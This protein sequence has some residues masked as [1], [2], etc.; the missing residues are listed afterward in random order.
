MDL[1]AAYDPYVVFSLAVG[2]LLALCVAAMV[3]L[4][5]TH[6]VSPHPVSRRVWCAAKHCSA[7]VDFVES[8]MTGMVHRS[9]QRC[10]LHDTD[11][12]CDEVCRYAPVDQMYPSRTE[13]SAGRI[14][15]GGRV[16]RPLPSPRPHQHTDRISSDH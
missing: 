11:G 8:V 16:L 2:L 10:S 3:T 1:L 5:D 12:R 9:V 4:R 13:T 14:R 6:R 7:E 15:D